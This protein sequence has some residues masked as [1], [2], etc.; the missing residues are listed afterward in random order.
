MN[1][2]TSIL[3]KRLEILENAIASLTAANGGQA[4][5]PP[6][7]CGTGADNA[8]CATF[9]PAGEGAPASRAVET[10]VSGLS[11]SAMLAMVEALIASRRQRLKFFDTEF[12]FDPSWTMLLD[13]FRAQLREQRISVSAVC[14]GSGVP[15]TTA[16]R[17]IKIMED[18]GYIV[19]VQDPNDKRRVFLVLTSLASERLTGYFTKVDADFTFASRRV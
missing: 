8:H 14:Y 5:E 3:C 10:P 7:R 9:G 19:R 4:P 15:E 12:F 16:L 17:Y 13:L 18:R 6:Q 2:D 1:S 11:R